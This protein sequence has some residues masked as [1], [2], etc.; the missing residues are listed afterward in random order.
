MAAIRCIGL[1]W[2]LPPYIL[3]AIITSM[4][5]KFHQDSSKTE[6]LVC[7]EK[8]IQIWIDAQSEYIYS[9]RSEP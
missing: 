8:D 7:I 4:F 3:S 9:M 5:A 6:R 1:I 2:L